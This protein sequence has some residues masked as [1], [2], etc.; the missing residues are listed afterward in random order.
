MLDESDNLEYVFVIETSMAMGVELL[1]AEVASFCTGTKLG[2]VD[3]DD[4]I[5]GA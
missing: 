3:W 5:A 2:S 1:E 4:V